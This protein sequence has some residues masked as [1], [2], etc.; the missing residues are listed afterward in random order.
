MGRIG[1]AVRLMGVVVMAVVSRRAPLDPLGKSS[2]RL[3]I[4]ARG[5]TT[6]ASGEFLKVFSYPARTRLVTA[7]PSHRRRLAGRNS[8]ITSQPD[9]VSCGLMIN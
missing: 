5:T 1:V 6:F 8:P 3:I 4:R 9:R 2:T 7:A